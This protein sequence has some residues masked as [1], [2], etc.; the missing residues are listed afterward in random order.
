M[1][2]INGVTAYRS[3]PT[4]TPKGALIVIHEIWG[5][6]DHIKDVADR[7]AAEG[8][9]VIAPDLLS[10]VGVTPEIGLELFA[11]INEPDDDK[12]TANQPRL[13][14]AFGQSRSPEFAAS[15]VAKLKAIVDSLEAEPDIDGKIGVLG[16]CFGGSY[17]FALAEADPRVKAA[18]PFYGG[19]QPDEVASIQCPVLAFYGET[20]TALIEALPAV[21]A[22]MADAGVDFTAKVYPDAGHAFFNDTNAR[23]FV[24]SVAGDAWGRSLE[25]ISAHVG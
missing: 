4:G 2:T 11:M 5:L 16:F 18:V 3:E 14:E 19:A 17:S 24:P 23:T 13:R 12:R 1:Q 22:A 21:E 15:A 25:F 6:V 7:Y 9:L 10:E 8:Y 20:D